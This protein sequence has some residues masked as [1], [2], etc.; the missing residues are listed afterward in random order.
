MSRARRPDWIEL[1]SLVVI[2]ARE[3]DLGRGHEEVASAALRAGCTAI[4]LRDKELSDR[5]FLEIARGIRS[6]CLEAGALFFVN[7][8]VHVAAE[9]GCG[10]HLG[11]ED[12]DIAAA[13]ENLGPGAII[14]YSPE[15]PA[16]AERALETGADYLGIGPVFETPSKVD[17]GVPIGL[18]GLARACLE[19][20]APV[21][22]IGGIDAGNAG[23]VV[24]SG[25]KGIAVIRA[26]SRSADMSA[27]VAALLDACRAGWALE[28]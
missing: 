19:H 9:L 2:T 21:I 3:A 10:V 14:G 13:R 18:E 15:R 22:A 16:Q 17:A 27:A 11:V 7:D 28:S 1:M 20:E 25:A 24:A 4:Q 8:R 5:A 23:S 6:R 26:V 12:M